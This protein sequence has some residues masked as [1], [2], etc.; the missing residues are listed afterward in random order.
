[1]RKINFLGLSVLLITTSIFF[2]CGKKDD[3]VTSEKVPYT[4]AKGY[5]IM[6]NVQNFNNGIITTEAEFQASFSGVATMGSAPTS[7]DFTKQNVIAIVKP[8]TNL[9][10]KL[11]AVSLTK[12]SDGKLEF[13]YK[14]TTGAEQTSYSRPILLVIFDKSCT[15]TLS[16]EEKN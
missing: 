7:I 10:P 4:E 1:M 15:G 6:N 3:K 8:V 9:S 5:F 16:I 11:T 2:A 12:Y 14:Y 13:V